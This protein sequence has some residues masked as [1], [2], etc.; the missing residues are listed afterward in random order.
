MSPNSRCTSKQF[1]CDMCP[2]KDMPLEYK[3]SYTGR[4]Y[5]G[6]PPYKCGIRNIVYLITCRQCEKQ[7][8]GQTYRTYRERII[9]HIGYIHRKKIDTTTGKHFHLPGHNKFAM[10]HHVIAIFRW[11]CFRNYPQLL[12]LED[13]LKISEPWNHMI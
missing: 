6:V 11:A 10:N 9:E 1:H 5:T 3:G 8:I 2:K 12:E 4:T 7:Y 13:S